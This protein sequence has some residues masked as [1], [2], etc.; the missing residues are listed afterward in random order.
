M[1]ESR[2]D[3]VVWQRSMDMVET[4]YHIADNL[5]S[6]AQFGLILQMKRAAVSIL[7]N[8][9]EGYGRQT[10]GNYVQFLNIARGSLL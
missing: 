4:V 1:I 10:S 2:K 9:A 3:L 8:I 6:K 7:S 5:P